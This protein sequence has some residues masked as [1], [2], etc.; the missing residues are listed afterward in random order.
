MQLQQMYITIDSEVRDLVDAFRTEAER[1]WHIDKMA[2]SVL[3]MASAQFLGFGHLVQGRD[4]SFL[5]YLSEATR[6]GTQLGLFGK[7]SEV[8]QSPA[9]KIAPGEVRATAYSA[10]GTFNWIMY[11]QESDSRAFTPC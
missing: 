5:A 10:W 1:L 8:N 7:T 11:V 9:N 4:R 6:I 2:P 3:T